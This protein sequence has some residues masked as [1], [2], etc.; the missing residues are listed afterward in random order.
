MIELGQDHPK[1]VSSPIL[2]KKIKKYYDDCKELLPFLK[3]KT[4]FLE[5]NTDELIDITLDGVYKCI[6]PLVIHIRTGTNED[7]KKE[8]TEKLSKEHGFVNLNYE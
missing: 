5:I 4:N 2:T 8:I 7:L 6:E 3:E 1:Y